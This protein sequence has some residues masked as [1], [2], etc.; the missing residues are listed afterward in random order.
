M[1]LLLAESA[2]DIEPPVNYSLIPPWLLF[3]YVA[4]RRV[5]PY[6]A[7][8][9]TVLVLATAGAGYLWVDA[10]LRYF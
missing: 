10:G 1:M 9:M 6:R 4:V 2:T 3:V 5:I 8:P 7:A